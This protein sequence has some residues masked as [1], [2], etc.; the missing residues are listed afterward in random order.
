MEIAEEIERKLKCFGIGI[1]ASTITL[2]N[3]PIG[4]SYGLYYTIKLCK[5]KYRYRKI[6]HKLNKEKSFNPT[7]DLDQHIL[8]AL[9]HEI[10]NYKHSCKKS[11]YFAIPFIGPFI[12]GKV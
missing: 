1:I 2:V 6:K 11:L 8:Y 3:V 4:L 12:C 7:I 5:S 9:H 10:K